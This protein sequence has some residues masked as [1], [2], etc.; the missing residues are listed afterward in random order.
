MIDIHHHL[1]YGVD[2]G[3][4][5][6]ETS[7]AMA[8]EAAEEGVTHIVCTPHASHQYPF[9]TEVIESRLAELRERL[10]GVVELSLGCDFHLT[11]DNV[12]DATSHPLR[13]S[14]GGKGYLM[15]EFPD[16]TIAPQLENALFRLQSAG[17]T[18]V[19]TH[20]ERYTAVQRKPELLA[21]W[22][23]KGCLVQVTSSSLYGRFG[24]AAEAF[25]NELL[26]RNWIHFLATD[27]HHPAWRPPH[28]KKGYDYVARKCGEETAIRLCETNPRAAVDGV[29]LSEQPEPRGLW[30][31]KP[32]SFDNK[33]YS[34]K[35]KYVPVPKPDAGTVSLSP[36][37]KGIWNRIFAR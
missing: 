8:Y 4:P 20:P 24:R 30:G 35:G 17:Y 31:H 27:A 32:L 21:E 37:V 6:L 14:I 12:A 29:P 10:E 33:R 23:R 36:A 18:L 26:E 9:H 5:D 15:V 7:V 16:V 11:A 3:A 25:S 2:D 19:I 34:S 22:V 1:I 28:L 13:Y